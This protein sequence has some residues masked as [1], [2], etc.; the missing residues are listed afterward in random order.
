MADSSQKAAD[1][2]VAGGLVDLTLEDPL[3]TPEEPVIRASMPSPPTSSEMEPSPEPRSM[4]N[5]VALRR[6]RKIRRNR[7]A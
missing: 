7:T 3:V 5:S 4:S 1:L 2:V 6:S